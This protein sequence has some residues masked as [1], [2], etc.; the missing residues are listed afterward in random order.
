M[1]SSVWSVIRLVWP[2]I[3][4]I[5]LCAQETEDRDKVIALNVHLEKHKT[6]RY[7]YS[8]TIEYVK[9]QR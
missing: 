9:N 1:L 3:G 8:L 2:E 7:T 5:N 4:D 6:L